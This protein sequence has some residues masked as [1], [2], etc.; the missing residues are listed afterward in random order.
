MIKLSLSFLIALL[1]FVPSVFGAQ[2]SVVTV[3]ATGFGQNEPEAISNAV[4]NGIAQVNGESIASSIKIKKVTLSGTNSN[5]QSARLI[6]KDLEQKTKGVVKSWKKISSTVSN[7]SFTANVLVQVYSLKKSDQLKRIKL[8]VV[9]QDNRSDDL[10]SHLI[11][12]LINTL[13]S[14]RKFAIIDRKNNEAINSELNAIR[15]NKGSIEDQVRLGASVAPDYIA[16][17]ISR[18]MQ[19]RNNESI[20][21]GSIE[22]L[23]YATRQVKFSERKTIKLRSTDQA[24]LNRQS[25]L[26]AIR[27]AR[28]IVETLYPPIV[29]GVDEDG[30]TISQGSDFFTKGD[31]C[32]IKERRNALRD[33]YTKEFLGYETVDIGEAEITYVDKRLSKAKLQSATQFDL[34]KMADK[35]YQLWRSG[36]TSEDLFKDFSSGLESSITSKTGIVEDDY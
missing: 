20:L 19:D 24:N 9:S 7:Q 33:P 34:E 1:L 26:L 3:T 12:G 22:I 25:N 8:A 27:L 23:D 18:I 21:E 35:K 30:I 15:A 29:I 4:I 2:I 36:Q 14:T 32:V 31:K 28:V 5:T 16:I 17:A 11:N 10:S 13:T 6:E